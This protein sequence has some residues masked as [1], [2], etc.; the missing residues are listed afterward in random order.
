MA[1]EERLVV[2]SKLG[3]VCLVEFNRP[4][5]LNAWVDDSFHHMRECLEEAAEDPTVAVVV[6]TGRGRAFSA[7]A[8]MKQMG[9]SVEG[10]AEGD[11]NIPASDEPIP[12]D[13]A[14]S[15]F[16]RCL[17]Q[18][19]SF[20]KPLIAAVNGVGVGWGMTILGHC[21]FVFMSSAARLRTPF[22]QLGLTA[23]AGS[24]ITFAMKMGWQNAAHVL[25]SA[26]WF[27]A[28]EARELGLVFKVTEPDTLIEETMA[29]AESLA[30]QPI[31]SLV[32]TK[33]SKSSCRSRRLISLSVCVLTPTALCCSA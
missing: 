15:A 5:A 6:V 18:V 33:V 24:S 29:Y 14:D 12:A 11:S 23:E 26:E 13:P 30:A 2:S 3:R 7:G 19:T 4:D 21:D 22:V 16:G 28:D 1:G 27:S 25:M 10:A 8:D 17:Q 9:S 20:P 31:D 32:A